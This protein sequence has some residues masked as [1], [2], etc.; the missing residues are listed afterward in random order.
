MLNNVLVTSKNY[1][2]YK[3]SE[4]CNSSLGEKISIKIMLEVKEMMKLS[5]FKT[6]TINMLLK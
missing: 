2:L 5:Y 4:K 1:Y 3:E 6:A